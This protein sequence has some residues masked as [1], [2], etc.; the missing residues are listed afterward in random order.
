[1]AGAGSVAGRI[2]GEVGDHRRVGQRRL[3]ARF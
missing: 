3:P 2:V 1:V